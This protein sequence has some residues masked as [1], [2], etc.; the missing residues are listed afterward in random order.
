LPRGVELC[1]LPTPFA[2]ARGGA[3]SGAVL[4]Y[5]RQGP[6]GAPTVVVLGGISAGRHASASAAVPERGWWEG[7]VGPDEAIDTTRF[8]V[9]AFDWLGGV[10]SS[11]APTDGEPFPFVDAE[12]QAR[13]LW[14]LVDQ[15]QVERVHAIVGSSYGGMVALHAAAQR[16][17]R[18]GRLAV[19]AAAHKSHA[20]AN[21]WRAVQR[22]IV[23]LGQ[24]TGTEPA[25]LALAR[26][27]ALTT[28]RTPGELADR[29]GQPG[30]VDGA[31]VRF[32]VQD[33]L[34][35]RS[36]DF[37]ARWN[38]A[39]FLCLN[40]SIDAHGIDPR[41]V[42]VPAWVL[43]FGGDQLVP[44]E[45]V[46]TLALALPEL[47]CHREVRSRYGHDA[48]LKETG[49]VATFLREVLS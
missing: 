18:V 38:A 25:A 32:P 6:A 3:L 31:E 7:I 10:G 27:L 40:R 28:Y 9:L 34:D 36:A 33:W 48:F 4:A 44:P 2:L 19:L 20:Q 5:E 14:H 13:A 17:A 12:D 39:A 23:E 47:R 42:T 35:A 22:G 11:T 16:P 37:A 29:F 46:R 8:A 49:P 26:Q 21:A 24:R 43:A 45:D 15:L 41:T 1:H 30:R